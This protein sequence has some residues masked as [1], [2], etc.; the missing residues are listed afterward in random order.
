MTDSKQLPVPPGVA[1]ER[2]DAALAKMLG[3]SRSAAAELCEAG[4]VTLDGRVA[5]KSDRVALDQW[6][7]V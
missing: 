7:T 6:V 1:G 5:G 3:L 2:L 4:H